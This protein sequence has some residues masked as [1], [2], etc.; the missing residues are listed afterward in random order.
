MGSYDSL[1][2][3]FSGGVDSTFVLKVA[4][5]VLG[6]EQVKAVTARS[7][8][9]S[10]RE[11]EESIALAREIDVDQIVIR[12]RELEKEGYRENSP[13]RCYFCKEE[14][15]Q[16]LS[17]LKESLGV[18]VIA[19][20]IN[21]DD[22]NDVRPGIQAAKDFGIRSPLLEAGFSK[23]DVRHF[24]RVLGLPTW[25]KPALACLSSRIPHG[26]EVTG[27]KLRQIEQGEEALWALGFRNVRL[28]H[29][30]KMARIEVDKDEIAKFFDPVLRERIL[31]SLKALGFQ[32]VTVDLE[33]YRQGSLSKV[34]FPML[35]GSPGPGTFGN[36]TQ[37]IC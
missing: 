11:F 14:L 4:R 19:N 28:R 7:E 32:Y 16:K 27:E 36:G 26:E 29:H 24:S 31:S 30:G 3:A 17:E 9:L 22:L 5:D 2:V 18:R 37:V 1:L 33:G 35:P 34:P 12:T 15:Y 6:K 21:C 20:G 25:D 10:S 23:E 13:E 8:S